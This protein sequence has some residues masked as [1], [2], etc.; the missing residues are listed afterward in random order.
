MQ[1]SVSQML[2]DPLGVGQFAEEH[3]R[4][5]G[6]FDG[7]AIER[8]PE[9]GEVFVEWDHVEADGAAGEFGDA[10]SGAHGLVEEGV[11]HGA[12]DQ[13]DD[14]RC[15][16][17]SA[18]VAVI[19]PGGEVSENLAG[20]PISDAAKFAL[21]FGLGEFFHFGYRFVD[22]IEMQGSTLD[23]FGVDGRGRVGMAAF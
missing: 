3:V 18:V 17:G 12:Q 7:D 22:T 9:A 19:D 4:A 6:A 21:L 8:A 23:V 11:L 10:A 13:L 2:A 5:R 15:G 1:F 16:K 20:G 14:E